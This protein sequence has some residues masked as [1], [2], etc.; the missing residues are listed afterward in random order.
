MHY[1]QFN[2][3]DYRKDTAH[4]TPIEHYIYRTLID[5]CYLDETGIPKKTQSVLRRLGLLSENEE[6][7]L[8][9]LGDFFFEGENAWFHQRISDEIV[10]YRG[11]AAKNAENGKKGGRPK[12]QQHKSNEV[13]D[14]KPKKTQSVTSGNPTESELKPNQELLTNNHK[15]IE[16]TISNEIVIVVDSGES[17]DSVPDEKPQTPRKQK[18]PDG[19]GDVFDY[20]KTVMGKT[21]QTVLDGKRKARIVWA[22]G[23]YGVETAK[24][25]IDGCKASAWHMGE[26]DKGQRY[27]DL[28]LIFRDASKVE[29]FLEIANAPPKTNLAIVTGGRPAPTMSKLSQQNQANIQAWLDRDRGAK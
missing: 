2:I 9:V 11:K 17:P 20:W 10:E 14:E 16:N 7:L 15:P 26:N 8:N 23:Q 29:N 5:W 22:I 4:L 13:E 19:V 28:T 24:R 6:S 27:D 1:Y 25:A 3:G 12:K 21:G 18:T